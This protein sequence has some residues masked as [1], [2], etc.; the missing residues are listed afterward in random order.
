MIRFFSG[1]VLIFILTFFLTQ[2]ANAQF[3]SFGL[4][5][6]IHI[7][8]LSIVPSAI[9]SNPLS[10][11]YEPQ[12]GY[13]IGGYYRTS[14]GLVY[15][16]PQSWIT[17]LNHSINYR[18]AFAGELRAGIPLNLIRLDL[19]FEMGIK[20]GPFLALY[21]PVFSLPLVAGSLMDIQLK[22]SGSWSNQFGIGLKILKFQISLRYEGP[23]TLSE[24]LRIEN[25]QDIYSAET[26]QIIGVVSMRF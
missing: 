7:S 13:H 4:S 22:K 19:P 1:K 10:F 17:I 2:R 26:S 3:S 21:A 23:I 20:V 12:T 24:A 15:F 5:V 16:E 8:N 11:Y 25:S 14:L 18:D 6:G 9:I